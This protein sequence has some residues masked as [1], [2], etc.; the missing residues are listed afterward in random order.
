MP[1]R[2]MILT[3]ILSTPLTALGQERSP[4]PVKV[5]TLGGF[6]GQLDGWCE[7]PGGSYDHSFAQREDL[8]GCADVGG[9]VTPRRPDSPFALGGLIGARAWVAEQQKQPE[10]IVVVS[11][12]NQVANFTFLD[13]RRLLNQALTSVN[14]TVDPKAPRPDQTQARF[15]RF[16]RDM[17]LL[18]ADAIGLATEDFVRSL[19]DPRDMAD[20]SAPVG[21]RPST[22]YRWL[23]EITGQPHGPKLVSSNTVVRIRRKGRSNDLNIVQKEGYSL[24]GV[25]DDESVGWLTELKVTHP[26]GEG[27]TLTLFEDVNGQ[28]R[29]VAQAIADQAAVS[30]TIALPEGTLQPAHQYVVTATI[31]TTATELRFQT[32]RAL[33][34][35][36]DSTDGFGGF[37]VITRVL[38][39][40]SPLLIVSLMDPGIKTLL[41]N[42]A[43]RWSGPGSG[44]PVDECEID[45]L[46]PAD[47]MRTLLERAFPNNSN[48]RKPIVLLISSLTDADTQQVLNEFPE[49]RFVVL[50]QESQML[51]RASRSYETLNE[52]ALTD[53]LARR[54]PERDYSG[55]Q[56]LFG[57]FNGTRPQAT[58][59]WVRPEWIGEVAATMSATLSYASHDEWT[60]DNE[61]LESWPVPGAALEWDRGPCGGDPAPECTIFSV[62]WQGASLPYGSFQAYLFCDPGADTPSDQCARMDDLFTADH[63]PVFAGD[64]LRRATGS[65]LAFVPG[66][67]IDPDARVWIDRVVDGQHTHLL[68]RFI[69]ERLIYRSFRIV[70]ASVSG[71]DLV[72]TINKALKSATHSG[73]CVVGLDGGCAES[74][75]TKKP[76]HVTI[77][78]RLVDARLYYAIAMPEGLAQELTLD[79]STGHRHTTDAVSALNEALSPTG[80]PGWYVSGSATESVSDRLA[81]RGVRELQHHAVVSSFEFGYTDLGLNESTNNA[82]SIKKTEIDFRS[83]TPSRTTVWKANIDLS[84]VDTYRIA[85]RGIGE[86]DYKRRT[87]AKNQRALDNNQWLAGARFDLKIPAAK[88]E[89]R[90]YVGY[91]REG[92]VDGPTE[93]L[94]A[95]I[96]RDGDDGFRMMRQAAGVTS[97]DRRPLLF[98]YAAVGMDLLNA[99]KTGS[100]RKVPVDITKVAIQFATGQRLN[101]PAGVEIGGVRQSTE[102]FVTGGGQAVLDAYFAANQSTFSPDVVMTAIAERRDRERVQVD[103]NFEPRWTVGKKTWKLGVELRGR[104]YPKATEVNE[105][106]NSVKQ[107]LRSRVSLTMPI[108]PRL[109]LVSAYEYQRAE[110]HRGGSGPYSHTKF[111]VT[112]RVPFVLRAGWGWLA[113]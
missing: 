82:G 109:E 97:F 61:Q 22:F 47:V 12:N 72:N 54:Q 27:L 50:P 75:N 104:L 98:Q 73:S 84:A 42:D 33:T 56:G 40:G 26:A 96:A 7:F 112:F 87:D 60:V 34:P 39:D 79:H 67:L 89:L 66:T 65:E 11:G 32:H 59:L 81:K 8:I 41:G 88:R 36:A 14:T 62:R 31:G 94:T 2:F 6:L 77:N 5:V 46:P 44:C 15:W 69:L 57:V 99:W 21:N 17:S 100:H 95:T 18:K 3:L 63:F 52:N 1:V 80:D 37:P 45:V 101:I 68:T 55:D 24:D 102:L 106:D 10:T 78:G 108:A 91:F 107:S 71:A 48:R 110:I 28:R 35:R 23:Q 74:I 86:I 13:E 113:K 93:Y 16:W 53:R 85:L 76:D 51:G 64:A 111:E 19:R 29:R 58:S 105:V 4:V 90:A 25:S 30:T 70:R 9:R 83:I 103:L 20:R 92:E 49:I 43:W 38:A